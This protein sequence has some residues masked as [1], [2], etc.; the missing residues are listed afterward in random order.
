[1]NVLRL[2][3]SEWLKRFDNSSFCSGGWLGST[4]VC[5]NIKQ[6]TLILFISRE[7]L[8]DTFRLMWKCA[9]INEKSDWTDPYIHIFNWK[10]KHFNSVNSD[11]TIF[12]TEFYW[13]FFP[14]FSDFSEICFLSWSYYSEA[15]HSSIKYEEYF[16]IS[17]SCHFEFTGSN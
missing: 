17:L 6:F 7:A 2:T 12:S 4:I 8:C 1:M 3:Q 16:Y 11:N 10:Q 13:F 14:N 5:V 15:V 9:W